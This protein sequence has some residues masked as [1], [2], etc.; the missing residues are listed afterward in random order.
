MR[1]L[2][3]F[4][5]SCFLS[6]PLVTFAEIPK[7]EPLV[8]T[9]Q[10]ESKILVQAIPSPVHLPEFPSLT[11]IKGIHIESVDELKEWV[12]VA[13]NSTLGT[14][15]GHK[16]IQS[17]IGVTPLIGLAI[18]KWDAPLDLP[19]KVVLRELKPVSFLAKSV[20]NRVGEFQRKK[21]VEDVVLPW[22][23]SFEQVW[24]AGPLGRLRMEVD[25]ARNNGRSKEAENLEEKYWLNFTQAIE[26][27]KYFESMDT[28]E[29]AQSRRGAGNE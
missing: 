23:I 9:V 16:P 4:W 21:S 11:P 3:Y 17:R 10:A 12:I 8:Y 18:P 27:R 19:I 13:E 29:P 26:R 2:N 25:E 5:L 6:V 7:L 20:D 14:I 24:S 1:H 15:G 28:E 22:W